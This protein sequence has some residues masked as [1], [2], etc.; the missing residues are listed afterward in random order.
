MTFSRIC[1]PLAA[2]GALLFAP[3]AVAEHDSHAADS[4]QEDAV[5]APALW[6]VADEDTTI[7]LFGTVHFLPEG[8]EWYT[9]AIAE[10]LESSQSLVK[11]LGPET[12][13]PQAFQTA[14][15]RHGLLAPDQSLSTMLTDEQNALLNARMLSLQPQLA[16][17]GMT[18][19]LIDRFQPWFA[20]INIVVAKFDQIGFTG[21]NGVERVLK[22]KSDGMAHE[23][24]ETIDYQF[25]IFAA[26]SPED[27]VDLLME[28]L[29]GLD[30]VEQMLPQ[31]AEL[32]TQGRVEELAAMMNADM[33][34]A[35]LLEVLLY[36]RNANWAEWI[37][38]R[39]EEP[40]TVF[41]AVGAGHLAGEK[42]VQDYLA[43]RA[44]ES[45]RI[46]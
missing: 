20:F 3:P 27:Q 4:Q 5:A 26:L 18:P 24:L 35:Q 17:Q 38:T 11:E 1:A 44:I 39:L 9:P 37:E 2:F 12:E 45:T 28:T 43:Q 34:E 33:Q 8:V 15:I 13:D 25:G 29:E 42:S 46:Q 36:K 32:W 22:A 19:E 31:M 40:G 6:K 16:K 14:I 7:Y 10:A 30:D 21:Q 23:G 41:I